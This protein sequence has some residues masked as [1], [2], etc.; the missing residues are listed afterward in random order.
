MAVAST[1]IVVAH[2]YQHSTGNLHLRES[3]NVKVSKLV[4]NLYVDSTDPF[5]SKQ[6]A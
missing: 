4:G 5:A 3:V 6:A 2:S 1:I